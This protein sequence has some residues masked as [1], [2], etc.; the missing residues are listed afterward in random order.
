M[1]AT[2]LQHR[3]TMS[4]AYYYNNKDVRI[5]Q[6][7]R[8]TI[9]DGELLVRVMSCG[10]CGSDVMEWFRV[11]KSPRILGHELAG[12]VE[13]SRSGAFRQGDRV[14]VRNQVP[15]GVCRACVS[16]HHSVC[17]HCDEIAP[18]G[19]SEY[20]RVPR[21]VVEGGVWPLPEGLPFSAAALA[22]P[23]ACVMHSQALA[24]VLGRRCVVVIGC[25][26]FGLLHLQ[27]AGLA[28][29]QQTVAIESQAFRRA[30][31]ADLGVPTI[32]DPGD[33]LVAEVRAVN[34]GHLAD[35]VIV[36]TGA[37]GA[38][39]AACKVIGRH[40]AILLF[41]MPGPE[42][43]TGLTVNQVFWRKELMVVSSY[44]PG[45][46]PF[47]EPL[48]LM[49]EGSINFERLITH[50]VPFAEV[51]RGFELVSRAGNSLKVVLDLTGSQ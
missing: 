25:G 3:L 14:V 7:D 20:V 51:Q 37:P 11:P 36:A 8:P 44:G 31:A 50:Q 6:A 35:M 39:D 41:G 21:K 46:V 48:R 4:V 43:T 38:L 13:E 22:E 10:I 45:N 23:L 47:S 12:V 2:G 5:E 26:V 34:D 19:M 16:G 32:L 18:G 29:V 49:L 30:A 33:D 40:G 42:V 27:A 1:M 9:S 28:G 17:E 24:R 15:C